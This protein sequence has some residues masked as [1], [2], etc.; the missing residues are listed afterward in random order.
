MSAPAPVLAILLLAGGCTGAGAPSPAAG[1]QVSADDRQFSGRQVMVTLSPAPPPIWA[2]I[3]RSLQEQHALR[4]VAAWSIASLG[5]E[6]CLV[7]DV[8]R[9]RTVEELV[10]RIG[11][12]PQVGIVQPIHEFETMAAYNDPYAHLQYGPQA[13]K[14]EQAHRMATGKGVRVAVVDTGVDVDHPDLRGRIVR[15]GNFVDR[16]EQSFTSEAHGTAVAGV[17]A[18]RANNE[19]GIVG[20]APEAEVLALKAC[21]EQPPG[22][23]RGVC[24]SY[25][26][27]KAVDFAILN[28]AQVLNFSLAGPVDP[29]LTRLI[30]RAVK[31]GVTV[32]AAHGDGQ[33]RGFPASLEGVLG[34]V[35]TDPE[36]ALRGGPAA[37]PRPPLA[38]PGV[39]I[40]TTAPRN[41]YDF[42]TGSSLAAAHVSGVVAL[43]LEKRPKLTPA[44][45]ERLFQG[46]SRQVNGG[47]ASAGLIDAC[48]ALAKVTEG[49]AACS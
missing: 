1:P 25:T 9:G 37:R 18:A 33:G 12:H 42:F 43:L 8:P 49:A 11:A 19:V 41:A 21:W 6:H 3:V 34:I 17:I 14:L 16:G 38:A 10:E 45:V 46:T 30:G 4:P 44:E 2:E 13:L 22:S 31:N 47:G 28:Q 32:V 23:R 26:L 5:G 29:L 27:A 36:G 48:A 40:L 24:N 7:F 20:V 15:V 35:A 39:D